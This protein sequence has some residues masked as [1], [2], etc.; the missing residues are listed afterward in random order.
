MSQILQTEK[1]AAAAVYPRM[2]DSGAL[3]SE[4][5]VCGAEN[6]PISASTKYSYSPRKTGKAEC[7]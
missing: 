6:W 3:T 2:H 7:T 1:P 4:R 5:R